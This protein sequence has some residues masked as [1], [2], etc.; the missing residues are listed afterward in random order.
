MGA[1]GTNNIEAWQLAI[2]AWEIVKQFKVFGYMEARA[3]AQKATELDPDYAHAWATLGFTYWW[4][5]RIG[6]TGDTETKFVRAAEFADQAMALDDS[7]STSI[8]LSALVA[9]PLGRDE[10]GVAVARRGVELYPGNAD[11]RAFLAYAL[12][13]AGHYREAVGHFRAAMS[14]NPFHPNWYRGSLARALLCLGEFDEALTRLDE[15]LENEPGNLLA[16]VNRASVCGQSGRGA[17]AQQSVQEIRRLAPNLRISH[18]LG[19]L[20]VNDEAAL[21]RFSDAVRQAG[22]PE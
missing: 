18:M 6:Y 12:T 3:L 7:G 19:I 14:L 8:G 16:W 20:L 17:A 11:V 5:G 10:E 9:A 22:L 21:K 13:S 4:E 1:G 2:G 15:I